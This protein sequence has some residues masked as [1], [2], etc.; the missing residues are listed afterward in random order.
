MKKAPRR[1]RERGADGAGAGGSTQRVGIGIRPVLAGL[2]WR[3]PHSERRDEKPSRPHMR[4]ARRHEAG[5][6]RRET[7][8]RLAVSWVHD[9]GVTI[10]SVSSAIRSTDARRRYRIHSQVCVVEA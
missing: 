3:K 10:R 8:G 7:L 2:T 9:P 5:H 6:G 4:D 1:G